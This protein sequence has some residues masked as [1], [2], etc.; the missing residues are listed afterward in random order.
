M[1]LI[2]NIPEFG[3]LVNNIDCFY[4]D[5]IFYTYDVITANELNELFDQK[6]K[7]KY[8]FNDSLDFNEDKY[9]VPV[10]SSNL[11][12]EQ[13][14]KRFKYGLDQNLIQVPETLLVTHPVNFS[15]NKKLIHRYL[16]LKLVELF[17]IDASYSWSG[18]GKNF[19][20]Q[21]LIDEYNSLL[22]PPMTN[23]QWSFLLSPI[24]KIQPKWYSDNEPEVINDVGISN[25]GNICL[26]W[27]VAIKNV[28]QHTG[29]SLITESTWTQK[30]IHFSEKTLYA[31]V[32][33][34]FPIWVGGYK[35]A[36]TW[37][38]YGFDTFSDI[39]NH[40]YQYRNTL[41]ERCWYAI[42]DNIDLITN[43]EKV[44]RLRN[45][46]EKRLNEN[47]KILLYENNIEQVNTQKIKSWPLDLQQSINPIVNQFRTFK[48]KYNNITEI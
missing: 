32:A 5:D 43:K 36:E 15:I 7:P 16:L 20:L 9:S 2:S 19:D 40:D 6:Q 24:K 44:Q 13:L 29:I 39:I 41:L 18:C 47:R 4:N 42:A 27:D 26:M 11:Y 22:S 14:V 8:I 12:L 23:D 3:T 34:T 35:Q 10:Y 17:K 21:Y 30:A 31:I 1:R 33:R 37:E 28:M 38:N 48:N 45:K 46:F 25:A